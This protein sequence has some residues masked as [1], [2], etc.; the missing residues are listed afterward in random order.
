MP[1]PKIP[2]FFKSRNPKQ[3]EYKPL[4]YNEAREE[5]KERRTRI[6]KELGKGEEDASFE[7]EVFR[8]RLRDRW[9]QSNRHTIM[10][11][12][13]SLRLLLIVGVLIYLSYLIL[14]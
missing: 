5:M 13:S 1:A 4:Y 3:F 10:M 11:Q 7:P 2:S 6:A 12:R 9:Q 8:S 14:N